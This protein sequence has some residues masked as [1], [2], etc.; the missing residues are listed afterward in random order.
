MRLATRALLVFGAAIAA[1]PALATAPVAA[2]GFIAPLRASDIRPA[3]S[4]I[5]GY[6]PTWELART[7]ATSL[8]Y[9]I[10]TTIALFDIP[11]RPDG[12]IGRSSAGYRGVMGDRAGAIV[13]AAHAAGVRVVVT[14]SSFSSSANASLLRGSARARFVREAMAVVV[15]RGADGVD[16]DLEGLRPADLPAYGSL[17]RSLTS[18]THRIDPAGRI[19]VATEANATGARMAAEA[20]GNGAD[21]AFV[22]S[23]T[24]RTASA[25]L[26]GSIDPLDRPA[27]PYSI[28]AALELYLAAGVPAKR[29]V[30]GLPLY[31]MTWATSGPGPA[32][33]TRGSGQVV[34]ASRLASLVP[35]G[36]RLMR[37]PGEATSAWSWYDARARTWRQAYLD[38]P[39]SIGLRERFATARGLAGIGLWALGYERGQSSYWAAIAAA[40]PDAVATSAHPP[41]AGSTPRD[42]APPVVAS[43]SVR[44]DRSR[45]RWVATWSGRDAASG[46]VRYRVVYQV[47]TGPYRILSD[48]LA[49]SARIA[50]SRWVRVRVAVQAFDGAGNGSAWRYATGR[51]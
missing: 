44:W 32:A 51:R 42:T 24:M 23:Y 39:T 45:G 43:M 13:R 19:S 8:R 29:T 16:L 46:I 33:A 18:A 35:P 30:L 48:G 10:L 40:R 27:S 49:T 1:L 22:M 6:L 25:T 14:F 20:T 47:G 38:D 9:D 3:T 28:R 50:A 31:G 34:L 15:A 37:D 21:A 5:V 11:V 4:E 7:P 2:A 36:A 17:V 41:Q 12:S 26:P